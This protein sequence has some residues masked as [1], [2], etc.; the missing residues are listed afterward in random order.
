MRWKSDWAAG[1]L[2]LQFDQEAWRKEFR[3]SRQNPAVE[4]AAPSARHDNTIESTRF[5]PAGQALALPTVA[6][7]AG[8]LGVWMRTQRYWVLFQGRILALRLSITK[9]PSF[10]RTTTTR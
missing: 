4:I 1:E 5:R 2:S 9:S 10:I 3:R 7:A 6:Q 8:L